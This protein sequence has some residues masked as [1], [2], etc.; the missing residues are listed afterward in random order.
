MGNKKLRNTLLA[1][2]LTPFFALSAT[3]CWKINNDITE[4]Q[5]SVAYSIIRNHFINENYLPESKSNTVKTAYNDSYNIT[6]DWSNSAIPEDK[7]DYILNEFGI[8]NESEE[9]IYEVE[10]GYNYENNSGYFFEKSHINDKDE[11]NNSLDT[12]SFR[13]DVLDFTKKTGNNF[14]NYRYKYNYNY[15]DSKIAYRVDDKYAVNQYKNDAIEDIEYDSYTVLKNFKANE[16]L[17]DLKQN[18]NNFG[19][20]CIKSYDSSDLPENLESLN[21]NSQLDI[22]SSKDLYTLNFSTTIHDVIFEE[23][24]VGDINAQII[25]K[26]SESSI[27]FFEYKITKNLVYNINC[28][29][30]VSS[31][32][33]EIN[34]SSSNYI[35]T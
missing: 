25:I 26:F 7:R 9:Y 21:I 22:T 16:T 6:T 32:L 10:Y 27:E 19:I 24:T 2:V 11:N 12:E 1:L 15:S 5:K 18:L 29:E 14:Y 30:E 13:I 23:E 34:F 31:L 33:P 3:G 20:D 8:S 4:E 35:S 17:N 28:E